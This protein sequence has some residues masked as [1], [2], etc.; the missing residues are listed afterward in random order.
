MGVRACGVV[1][2]RRAGVSIGPSEA[3]I[4]LRRGIWSSPVSDGLGTFILL[5]TSSWLLVDTQQKRVDAS[6]ACEA[7]QHCDWRAKFLAIVCIV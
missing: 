7:S 6:I 1:S 2:A 5:T 3:G 4:L